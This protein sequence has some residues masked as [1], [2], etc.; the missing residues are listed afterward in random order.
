[1]W[2]ES[3]QLT[4][5]IPHVNLTYWMLPLAHHHA[6]LALG[7]PFIMP[8]LGAPIIMPALG[9]PI[10]MPFFAFFAGA[11]FGASIGEGIWAAAG[12]KEEVGAMLEQ[13]SE[14]M[15]ERELGLSW[16]RE[17]EPVSEQASKRD[18]GL[19]SEREM[20][21]VSEQALKQALE[22]ESQGS[23]WRGSQ[24][25]CQRGSQCWHGKGSW[26]PVLEQ[27]SERE[28]G[29]VSERESGPVY[30]QALDKKLG[31]AS[32]RESGPVSEWASV[33]T[34]ERESIQA[35][36]WEQEWELESGRALV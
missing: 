35:S 36:E 20:G 28:S 21:M 4:T 10:I 13:V 18:L 33:Q 26:G 24:D 32:E 25:W 6:S 34:L 3:I 14:Q 22:R 27:V 9:T 19:A 8:A 12:I 23:C 15:L 29:L 1:M 2:M 5:S 16:E 30:E 7:A 11:G 31:L 17:L